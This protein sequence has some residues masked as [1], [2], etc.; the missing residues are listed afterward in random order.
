ML[1]NYM[2]LV[3][4]FLEAIT[5]YLSFERLE[6]YKFRN[7]EMGLGGSIFLSE[8]KKNMKRSKSNNID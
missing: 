5:F 1:C 8:G 3:K 6:P 2:E 7:G 4:G